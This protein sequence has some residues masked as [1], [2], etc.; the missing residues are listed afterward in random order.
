MRNARKLDVA[1][2]NKTCKTYNKLGLRNIIRFGSQPNRTQRY[3]C[4]DCKR[5]FARTIN[6]PFFHKHLK[7]EEIIRICKLLSEKTSFRAIARITDH[8][9]DT[10]RAIATAIALHC[11]KFNE[12]FIKELKLSSIEV[13]EMWSF[14]K[15]K[16]KIA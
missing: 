8:H 2:P 1:C 11:K 9:L 10:I 7:K 16:K 15:K 5:T 14:V 3:K 13:D 12:Y 4:T 6:T